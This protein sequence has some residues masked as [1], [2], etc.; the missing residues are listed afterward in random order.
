MVVDAV[1]QPTQAERDGAL[2][3]GCLPNTRPGSSG[4]VRQTERAA[5]PPRLNC[6]H[7][8]E[9]S[10]ASRRPEQVRHSYEDRAGPGDRGPVD[11]PPAA[12][13]LGTL[14]D[15]GVAVDQPEGEEPG[16]VVPG[17]W[18]VPF[19]DHAVR[20][21]IA[22]RKRRFAHRSVQ[23]THFCTQLRVRISAYAVFRTQSPLGPHGRHVSLCRSRPYIANTFE[24][25]GSVTSTRVR[26]RRV[27]P[28]HARRPCDPGGCLRFPPRRA[29]HALE[30][31]R[32][33]G[34]R[35]GHHGGAG[36]RQRAI[37]GRDPRRAVGDAR[38]HRLGM[39][40]PPSDLQPKLGRCGLER[41]GAPY[42]LS[43]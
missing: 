11:E 17:W 26:H 32:L 20:R 15:V 24:R 3:A 37:G 13:A 4:V 18:R 41:G 36:G 19:G 22:V 12:V 8:S 2:P 43:R 38:R 40:S 7:W 5:P 28:A 27:R 10:T 31:H 29:V 34:R 25:G 23:G 6:T 9:P 21:K 39:T 1:P 14:H 42:R 33:G 30:G 35:C 16:D